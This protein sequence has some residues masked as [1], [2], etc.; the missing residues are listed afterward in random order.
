MEQIFIVSSVTLLILVAGLMSF[1]ISFIVNE[2]FV[3]DP[4]LDCF[5]RDPSTLIVFSSEPLDNCTSYDST[6]GTVVCF[7]FI[8]DL[9]K[10]F[11]SAVGFIGV[12]VG[13]CRLYIYIMIWL[14]KFFNKKFWI[15][16]I[17]HIVIMNIFIL[18][19]IVVYAIPFLS[20]AVFKTNKSTVIFIAYLS[21]FGYF[22][23]MVGGYVFIFLIIA[24]DPTTSNNPQVTSEEE[25]GVSVN[26]LNNTNLP[27][28]T[29]L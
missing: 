13:C 18:I 8:F 29:Q 20:D 9:S 6:N 10:G 25:N 28:E 11:S 3:C 21:T 1:W 22:G 16:C 14:W 23:P 19:F 27:Q 4:Q 24:K 15:I 5:L 12:A 17:M 2:T 7:E 26:Q